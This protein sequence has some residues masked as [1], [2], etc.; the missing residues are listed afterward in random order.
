MTEHFIYH[1]CVL[2]DDTL[3]HWQL[4]SP[5]FFSCTISAQLILKYGRRM[6]CVEFI[7]ALTFCC[8]GLNTFDV[9]FMW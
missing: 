2:M 6:T 5:Q 3:Q 8:W 9:L 1:Y 4:V 7:G